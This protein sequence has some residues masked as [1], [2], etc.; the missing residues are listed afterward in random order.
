MET[1]QTLKEERE[2]E[3]QGR[4]EFYLRGESFICLY[5]KSERDDGGAEAA[6]ELCIKSN[7]C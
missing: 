5:L 1:R 2:G 4:V 3:Q 6:Y 7:G